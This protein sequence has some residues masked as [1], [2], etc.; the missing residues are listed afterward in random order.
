MLPVVSII[1]DCSSDADI[2]PLETQTTAFITL[3][4]AAPPPRMQEDCDAVATRFCRTCLGLHTCRSKISVVLAFAFCD[5]K[6]WWPQERQTP[7]L[8]FTH[9]ST[10]ECD[11]NTTL[12]L[13]EDCSQCLFGGIGADN[14]VSTLECTAVKC[15]SK[16]SARPVYSQKQHLRSGRVVILNLSR[17]N[18]L[19]SVGK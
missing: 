10:S 7:A 3:V 17:G 14:I 13:T 1:N 15:R 8:R 2:A 6:I 4:V 12:G 5:L 9:P 11:R 19:R 18:V 16:W